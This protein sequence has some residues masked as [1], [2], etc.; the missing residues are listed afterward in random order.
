GIGRFWPHSNRTPPEAARLAGLDQ[1]TEA[2]EPIIVQLTDTGYWILPNRKRRVY[3]TASP[4]AW[5]SGPASDQPRP[6]PAWP[7]LIPPRRSRKRHKRR[8]LVGGTRFAFPQGGSS[9]APFLRRHSDPRR[10][11]RELL[12]GPDPV[13]GPGCYDALSARLVEEAGFQAAYMTGF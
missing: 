4:A 12:A 8:I 9:T 10:R 11:L 2:R 13:L 6:S 7:M 5:P 1:V 3:R